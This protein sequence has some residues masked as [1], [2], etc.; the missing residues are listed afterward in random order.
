MLPEELLPLVDAR[1][2]VHFER[3]ER[4]V[5]TPSPEAA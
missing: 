3:A 5:M 4:R 2:E 1:R